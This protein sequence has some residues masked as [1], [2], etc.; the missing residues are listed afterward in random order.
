MADNLNKKNNRLMESIEQTLLQLSKSSSDLIKIVSK[1]LVFKISPYDF[2][3][4]KFS[5]IYRAISTYNKK[6][7][8]V[9]RLSGLYSP[10]FGRETDDTEQEPFSLIVNVDDKSFRQGFI[11][12]SPEIGKAFRMDQ[13]TYFLLD[14]DSYIPYNLNIS[15]NT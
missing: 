9:I 11:W 15:K 2:E 3:Q 12:Y 4:F 7:E 5:A 1:S 8:S 10:L 14:E 13:L 6:R